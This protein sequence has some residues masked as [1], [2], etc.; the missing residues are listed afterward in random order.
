MYVVQR[1]SKLLL[2]KFFPAIVGSAGCPYVA[3]SA[4]LQLQTPRQAGSMGSLPLISCITRISLPADQ[5]QQRF[6][7]IN[8]ICEPEPLPLI[9]RLPSPLPLIRRLPSPLPLI[10]RL[11][12]PLPLLLTPMSY[13]GLLFL[14]QLDVFREPHRFILSQVIYL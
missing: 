2:R 3:T 1:R 9:R 14:N 5:H 10:R 13:T 11:P 8:R 6:C 7:C 12:S 4:A